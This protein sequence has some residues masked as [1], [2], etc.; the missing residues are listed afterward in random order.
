MILIFN[1]RFSDAIVAYYDLYIKRSYASSGAIYRIIPSLIA[2]VII[3]Q[4]RSKFRKY[5][6]DHIKIYLKMAFLVILLSIIIIFS[7]QNSTLADRF[8]L[9]LTPL[10]LFVFTKI[11]KIGLFNIK[12]I[13]YLAIF[14]PTYFFYTFFWLQYAV[15]AK[16]FVPYKNVLFL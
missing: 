14:C 9:Y 2:A 7:P 4:K 16:W 5:F 15:H 1:A 13:D 10:T 12:K 8:A 11:V 6:G 3:I